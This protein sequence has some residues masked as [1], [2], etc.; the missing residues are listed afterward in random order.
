M[1][2]VDGA[3]IAER[4]TSGMTFPCF[5]RNT[6][7]SDRARRTHRPD[8]TQAPARGAR[9]P[10]TS[11]HSADSDCEYCPGPRTRHGPCRALRFTWNSSTWEN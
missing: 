3:G 2:P 8:A 7:S 1:H 5:T 10:H 4:A 11:R 6:P 9:A